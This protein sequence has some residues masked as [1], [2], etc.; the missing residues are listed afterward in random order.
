MDECQYGLWKDHGGYIY[1]RINR[2]QGPLS[3]TIDINNPPRLQQIPKG[4]LWG[5]IGAVHDK[6]P[7]MANVEGY[8]WIH[9][10]EVRVEGKFEAT[11]IIKIEEL[12][13]P[14]VPIL[15]VARI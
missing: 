14:P 11:I 2:I 5:H 10:A 15:I 6:E 13:L 3:I 9:N 12:Q 7:I 8:T 4:A 1:E